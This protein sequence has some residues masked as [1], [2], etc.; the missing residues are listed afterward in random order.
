MK[1]VLGKTLAAVLSVFALILIILSLSACG[2]YYGTYSD[3]V[4][5]YTAYGNGVTVV[6]CAEEAEEVEIP[7]TFYC[8]EKSLP[9]TAISSRAFSK[10]SNLKKVKI[11]ASVVSIEQ[12]A[13]TGCLNITDLEISQDN[14]VY[15]SAG[16]CII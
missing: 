14:P 13:F 16:N 11:P 1:T 2:T 15:R 6:C 12:S 10:C 3:G 5:G 8:D 9:V 7:S 4:L